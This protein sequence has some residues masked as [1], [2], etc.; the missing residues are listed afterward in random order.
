[1]KTI[2][3]VNMYAVGKRI[4]PSA[5]RGAWLFALLIAFFLFGMTTLV[6]ADFSPLD[7]PGAD[8]HVTRCGSGRDSCR[9]RWGFL[10]YRDRRLVLGE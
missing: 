7:Q 3:E 9:S 10:H 8:G 5:A 6:R 1:M 2:A 4:S